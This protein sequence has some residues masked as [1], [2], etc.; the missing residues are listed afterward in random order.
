M[1]TVTSSEL[2]GSVSECLKRVKAGEPVLIVEDG[3]PIGRIMPIRAD[4]DI[5]EWERLLEMERRGEIRTYGTGQVSD[6]FFD[7]PR[8]QDPEGLT[9]KY[10][11]EERE[12]GW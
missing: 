1:V 2:A 6:E 10:L 3:R 7:M 5:A 4:E 8:A 12:S 11:L 9:L